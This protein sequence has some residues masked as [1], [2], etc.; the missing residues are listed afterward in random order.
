MGTGRPV[1]AVQESTLMARVCVL[2]N[3]DRTSE[4]EGSVERE[5]LD[6]A[7]IQVNQGKTQVWNRSWVRPTDCDNLFFRPHGQPS[8]VWRGDHALPLHKQGVT[9]LGTPL[10]HLVFVEAQLS[11]KVAR[12]SSRED[13]SGARFAMCVALGLVLRGIESKLLPSRHSPR[14]EFPLRGASR[15][16]N[17]RVLR[18]VVAE[19]CDRRSVANGDS[20]VLFG[21]LG[22]AERGAH[23]SLSPS[24][25][26]P[27]AP[28]QYHFVRVCVK[29]SP[30]EGGRR[31]HTNTA[32]GQGAF[33]LKL[34][35]WLF[36]GLGVEVFRFGV[37]G[38]K[39]RWGPN[40]KT[41]LLNLWLERA[42]RAP[43]W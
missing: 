39:K 25:P 7:R 24:L 15:H 34:Q 6:H 31:L 1:D 35:R 14:T 33:Q 20:A 32:Q 23:P 4:V 18:T 21:S 38:P 12:N 41:L 2:S 40:S 26:T 10:G 43:P 11:E 5:L 29:A 16:R 9:I 8:D 27:P 19:S 28:K 13:P 37:L 36:R 22:F 30:F 17:Q 3:P 42:T